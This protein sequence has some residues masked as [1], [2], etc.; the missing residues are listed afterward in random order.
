MTSLIGICVTDS[1]KLVD[2]HNLINISRVKEEKKMTITRFAGILG[3][4]LLTHT[5]SIAAGNLGP[6]CTSSSLSLTMH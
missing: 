2:Y 3:W 1:W 6:E 4:Q 5:P